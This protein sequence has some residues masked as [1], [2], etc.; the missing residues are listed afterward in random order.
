MHAKVLCPRIGLCLRSIAEKE[1]V[2]LSQRATCIH[3]LKSYRIC[4]VNTEKSFMNIIVYSAEKL[5]CSKVFEI[6]NGK[7]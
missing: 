5:N 2:L 6:W 3:Q 4:G 7:T 1:M